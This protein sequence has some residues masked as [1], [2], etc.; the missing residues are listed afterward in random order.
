MKSSV[1]SLFHKSAEIEDF[2][3]KY[4]NIVHHSLTFCQKLLEYKIYN[5]DERSN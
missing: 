5:T 4:E 2:C 3:C 1:L